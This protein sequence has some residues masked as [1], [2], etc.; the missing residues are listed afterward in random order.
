MA[1]NLRA[2]SVRPCGVRSAPVARRAAVVVRA[3]QWPDAALVE[4]VKKNF[5]AKGVADVEEARALLDMGYT[6]VDVRPTQECEN[7]GR[8]RTSVNVPIVNAK[9]VYNSSTK[10][11]ELIKT[12]NPDFVKQFKA[13]FPKTEHKLL[14]ACGNGKD[15]SIDA[16]L[17]LEAA[18]YT[19]LAGLKGGY[20]AFTKQFDTTL[21]RKVA[22]RAL[23]TSRA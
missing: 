13:K 15:H 21:K 1:F 18:G 4:S 17:A 14:I 19:N 12:P 2:S 5:P 3:S 20:A 7:E 9:A 16:L 11:R 23:V 22:T 6:Y 8:I 10:Q